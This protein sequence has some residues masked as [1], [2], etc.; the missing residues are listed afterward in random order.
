MPFSL[1]YRKV[2]M[3]KKFFTKFN[4]DRLSGLTF[5]DESLTEQQ[6][7]FE[8]DINNIVAGIVAKE[9]NVKPPQY[10]LTITP[11]Q[12]DDALNIIANARSQFEELPS[13]LRTKFNND[14]KE[15]LSFCQ[16]ENNY[17]EGVKL[18]LFN[19]KITQKPI[20]V[21]ITNSETP[22]TVTKTATQST[23]SE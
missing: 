18:G 3:S 6:F 22:V 5:Q 19:K 1:F 12:F 4:H 20:E 14:P 16:D 2:I 8:T 21:T 9:Y 15:L 13:N 23:S 11:N 10:G 17:E 7:S